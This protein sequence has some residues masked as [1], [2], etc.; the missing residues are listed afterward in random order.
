MFAAA[1]STYRELSIAFLGE[2][3]AFSFLRFFALFDFLVD[4]L[5]AAA[6]VDVGKGCDRVKYRRKKKVKQVLRRL[7]EE[8]TMSVS[9]LSIASA[10]LLTV[11]FVVGKSADVDICHVGTRLISRKAFIADKDEEHGKK[12]FEFCNFSL[13]CSFFL[14]ANSIFA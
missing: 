11:F 7:G 13:L 3:T 1:V 9:R 10:V 14:L 5:T 2:T 8:T 12:S 6:H 4:A